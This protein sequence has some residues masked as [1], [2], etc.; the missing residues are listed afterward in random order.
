MKAIDTTFGS[1]DAFV[2][3]FT[4]VVLNQFG[5]GWAW[6]VKTNEWELQIIATANQDSPLMQGLTPVLWLD[7]REHAYYLKYQNKRAD[8]IKSWFSI[9]NWKEVEKNWLAG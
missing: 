6:L 8:Y 1:F 5:S 7:V 4:T 9:V 3:Q 2:E